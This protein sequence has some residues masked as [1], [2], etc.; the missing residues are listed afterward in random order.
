MERIQSLNRVQQFTRAASNAYS[1]A[2]WRKQTQMIGIFTIF[3]TI[4]ALVASVYLNIT[5]RTAAAGRDIEGFQNAEKVLNQQISDLQT[6][7]ATITSGMEMEKRAL[8]LGFQPVVMNQATYLVVPQYAGRQTVSLASAAVP[9]LASA[10]V[11]PPEYTESLLDWF[12]RQLKNGT[13]SGIRVQ[14]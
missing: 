14:P 1:Q 5:A 12:F 13:F 8:A 9:E 3:V 2:P 7:L 4:L 10:A 11:M 6:Q